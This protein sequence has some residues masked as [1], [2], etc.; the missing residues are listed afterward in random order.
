[1]FHMSMFF[2]I[3]FYVVT[4]KLP[5]RGASQATTVGVGACIYLTVG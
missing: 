1:M 5:P 2:Y 3:V 4:L